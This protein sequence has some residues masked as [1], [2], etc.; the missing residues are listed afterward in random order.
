[1]R[2]EGGKT[3][4]ADWFLCFRLE[5]MEVERFQKQNSDESMLPGDT[6]STYRQDVMAYQKFLKHK[7]KINIFAIYFS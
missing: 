3:A 4:K 7:G 1:M 5:K 2:K 6:L